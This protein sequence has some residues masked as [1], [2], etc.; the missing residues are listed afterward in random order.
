MIEKIPEDKQIKIDDESLRIITDETFKSA[1]IEREA[2]PKVKNMVK[3]VDSRFST[4]HHFSNLLKCQCG[5]RLRKKVQKTSR[6]THHYYYCR[7]HELYGN[8]VCKCRNLQREEELLDWVSEELREF[9]DYISN[10]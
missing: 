9:V 4:A 3:G 10:Y 8:E 1:Q 2:R 7:N 6:Q 5:G